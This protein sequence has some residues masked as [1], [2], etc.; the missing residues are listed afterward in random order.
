MA[1]EYQSITTDITEEKVERGKV[2]KRPLK[3]P[4]VG[5]AWRFT[6]S[7]FCFIFII[8]MLWGYERMGVLSSWDR[9]GFNTLNILFSAFVSLALGSLLT[10]LGHTLRW[11]LLQREA[12]TPGNVDLIL[13]IGEPTGSL[14]LLW[15]HTWRGKGWTKT[16]IIVLLYFIASI[17]ARISVAG[18]G[19][20]FELNE[21]AGVDYPVMM[22]DWRDPGWIT[23]PDPR[24][25]LR[26]FVDF[27]S[28]GL[29][30]SPL[31]LNKSD[32]A[33]W[34]TEN[35]DGLGVNRT[36]DG[37][38]LTYTFSLNEYR[39]LEVESNKDHVVHSSSS[40][41]V[42]NFYNGT[43]YQDGKSVG[44]VTATNMEQ[45]PRDDPEYL[46]ILSGLLLHFPTAFVDYI[47]TAGINEET[48][49]QN[50]SGCMTTY[51]YREDHLSWKDFNKRNA[52]YFGCTS[53][54][55][56][57]S[58]H[59]GSSSEPRAGLSP[60]VFSE[61]IP[62]SNSSFATYMLLGMGT[63]ER[64]NQYMD[65]VNLFTRIYSAMDKQTHLVNYAGQGLPS[66]KTMSDWYLRPVP[67]AEEVYVAHLA[68]RL[69]ILGFVGAQR[70]LPKITKEKG[71]SEKPFIRT[72][73]QVKWRRA[74]AVMIAINASAVFVILAVYLACRKVMIPNK[75]RDSPLLT[76]RFLNEFIAGS[77]GKTTGVDTMR[78][79]A[80]RTKNVRLRYETR[81][82]ELGIWPVGGEESRVLP[83]SAP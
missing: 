11:H 35:V 70:Q 75:G 80:E 40:C 20:T 69:P 42:R 76:A 33:S 45:I 1:S 58:A 68:A 6:G 14:R 56:T 72:V 29:A 8:V 7:L 81:G 9:R 73:L 63:Y 36:V 39:G 38:T 17:L 79:I 23:E 46:Q 41:I 57:S 22:T 55:S 71:A 16:T 30:T 47:W 34:T 61:L 64:I 43:V 44:E 48:I 53:C 83:T 59:S 15:G 32:P 3:F 18:L 26:R 24:E 28:V 78:E 65:P 13:G 60:T 4:W 37:R 27:A 77:S 50:T 31:S 49:G 66:M 62:S 12:A 21:E 67:I 74:M 25:T 52:S 54:L 51:I 82:G 5:I 19:L 10:L 2:E